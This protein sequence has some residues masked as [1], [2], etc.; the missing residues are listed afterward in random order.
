MPDA[1]LSPRGHAVVSLVE[2]DPVDVLLLG[3]PAGETVLMDTDGHR[4][5]AG[6]SLRNRGLPGT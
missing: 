5:N 4:R 3:Q 1:A 6:M 2:D